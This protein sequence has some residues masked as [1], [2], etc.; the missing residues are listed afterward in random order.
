VAGDYGWAPEGE[1]RLIIR[2]ESLGRVREAPTS[3]GFAVG[4]LIVGVV[5]RPD[6]VPCGACARGHFDMCRGTTQGVDGTI[7]RP[8]QAWWNGPPSSFRGCIS[9]CYQRE[10]DGLLR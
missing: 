4:D 6:P 3:S 10:V 8:A 9:G 2:H 5:R 7:R 1:E